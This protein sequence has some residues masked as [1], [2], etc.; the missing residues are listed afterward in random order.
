M[1]EVVDRGLRRQVPRDQSGLYSAAICRHNHSSSI[2][3][4]HY[5]IGIGAGK[6][7]VDWKTIADH[8]GFVSSNQP[9]RG[10]SVL[11]DEPGEEVAYLPV[12][13]NIWLPYPDSDI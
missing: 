3:N 2:A 1:L 5:S 10:D 7:S 12:S 8:G 6:R 4:R 9:F 13:P 11:L